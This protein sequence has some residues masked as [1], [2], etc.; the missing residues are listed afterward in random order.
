MR[1]SLAELYAWVSAAGVRDPD[2]FPLRATLAAIGQAEGADPN[3]WTAHDPPKSATAPPSSGLFQVHRGSWPVIYEHTELVR[4]APLSDRDKAIGMTELVKPILE[5]AYAHALLAARILAERGIAG[6][7]LDTAL[8]IDAAWQ[9]GGPNLLAW[10][11]RTRR[12]DPREIVNPTR[13][14]DVEVALRTLAGDELGLVQGAGL[15]LGILAGFALAGVVLS[16]WE[17]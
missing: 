8:F 5:D 1:H 11:R 16:Q 6:S 7:P 4:R 14:V 3:A 10:A 12:G 17:T 2:G 13:T 15:L 9:T